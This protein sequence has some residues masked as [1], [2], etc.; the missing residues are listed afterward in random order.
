MPA[1]TGAAGGQ[2]DRLARV[3]DER[4]GHDPEKALLQREIGRHIEAAIAGLPSRERLV[5]E[6]RHY[7]GLRL[8]TIGEILETSEETAR[9][10]LFRAHRELRARL[11]DFRSA[12]RDAGRGRAGQFRAEKR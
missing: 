8:K 7:Q 11:R 5:F 1:G 12:T 4:P 2:E 3:V 10:C 9:N 6:M